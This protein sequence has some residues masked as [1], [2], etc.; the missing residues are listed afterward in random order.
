VEKVGKV[1]AV[2]MCEMAQEQRQS[3]S[4]QVPVALQQ[5]TQLPVAANLQRQLERTVVVE[6]VL[7]LGVA[8]QVQPQLRTTTN[9]PRQQLVLTAARVAEVEEVQ[10]KPRPHRQSTT[11]KRRKLRKRNLLVAWVV[12]RL[13]EVEVEVE[14]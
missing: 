2:V 7:A 14:Q 9:L 6:R 10:R 8:Q 13:V 4:L 5:P 12:V 11:K 1:V 3:T